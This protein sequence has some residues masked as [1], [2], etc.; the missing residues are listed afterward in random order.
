[1]SVTPNAHAKPGR[2]H[3]AALWLADI[4]ALRRAGRNSEADAEM[5]RFRSTYPNYATDRSE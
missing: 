4:H 2:P 1:V 3:A 5:R